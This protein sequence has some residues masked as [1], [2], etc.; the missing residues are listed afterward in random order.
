MDPKMYSDNFSTPGIYSSSY[1]VVLSKAQFKLCQK[2]MTDLV[3]QSVK[4]QKDALAHKG[5]LEPVTADQLATY[6]QPADVLFA[7]TDQ[8][9]NR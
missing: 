7:A 4:L 3:P 9:S 2:A 1:A 5:Y 6:M 8:V